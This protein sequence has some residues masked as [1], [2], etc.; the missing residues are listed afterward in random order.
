[1]TDTDPENEVRDVR[2]PP[3]RLVDPKD[4]LASKH[5]GP[6]REGPNPQ[7]TQSHHEAHPPTPGWEALQW[8]QNIIV[9]IREGFPSGNENFFWINGVRRSVFEHIGSCQMQKH[10]QKIHAGRPSKK[11]LTL[12]LSEGSPSFQRRITS[13]R[14]K[15]NLKAA[16]RLTFTQ[17]IQ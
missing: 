1:M 8:I 15:T 11:G 3:A 14:K 2:T 10:V 9:H 5:K 16:E 12:L 4:T 17:K 13:L 6:Y 7:C